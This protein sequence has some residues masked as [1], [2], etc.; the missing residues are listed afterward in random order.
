M[1]WRVRSSG[2]PGA[3][4]TT[5]RIIFAATE[6]MFSPGESCGAGKSVEGDEDEDSFG[7]IIS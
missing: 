2:P 4:T 5:A 1:F 3:W 6:A 7:W